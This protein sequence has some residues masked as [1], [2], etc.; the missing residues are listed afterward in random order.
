MQ[1]GCSPRPLPAHHTGIRLPAHSE[2]CSHHL[3]HLWP[4]SNAALPPEPVSVIVPPSIQ[5]LGILALTLGRS[6]K[7]GRGA[8]VRLWLPCV[9]LS[10]FKWHPV[11][12][13]HPGL[14]GPVAPQGCV[15]DVG[16]CLAI[17]SPLCNTDLF[18]A[19]FLSHHVHQALDT[20]TGMWYLYSAGD[21]PLNP[22][23]I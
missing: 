20:Q 8:A 9:S 3:L 6:G 16:L 13:A 17:C 2:L 18:R 14:R 11:P 5:R 4:Q 23:V 19:R 1:A 12:G 22:I 7:H 15:L 10:V 21:T